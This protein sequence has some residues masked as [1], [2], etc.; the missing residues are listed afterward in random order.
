MAE[1]CDRTSCI[2]EKSRV[3]LVWL[4]NSAASRRVAIVVAQQPTQALSTPDLAALAPKAWFGCNELV[5]EA[6]M[7]ALRM[8]V[9]QVLVDRIIQGTFTQYHH[10]TQGLLLDGAYKPFTVGIQI[11]RP[12]GQ[13]ERFHTAALQQ[14]IKRLREFGVPIV[15]EISFPEEEPVERIGQLSS[16]LLH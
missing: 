3:E 10:L 8:I 7:I 12:G 2:T 13:D 6:L 14:P 15:D 9:G 4:K 1:S 5:I 11:R 16:T